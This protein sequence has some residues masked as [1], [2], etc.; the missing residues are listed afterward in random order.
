MYNLSWWGQLW[1]QEQ[2]ANYNFSQKN[3]WAKIHD[4]KQR[5]TN[6]SSVLYSSKHFKDGARFVGPD[7]CKYRILCEAKS[8]AGLYV[9]VWWG[10]G[11]TEWS[12]WRRGTASIRQLGEKDLIK[13]VFVWRPLA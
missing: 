8:E 6:T 1:R 4:K 3:E 5:C 9:V 13:H 12:L 11:G 10:G 2:A 7:V